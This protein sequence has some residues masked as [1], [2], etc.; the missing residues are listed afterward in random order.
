MTAEEGIRRFEW[1]IRDLPWKT[2]RD[3]VAELREHLAELPPGTSLEERLGT[4]E[5]YAADLRAA[6]GL[7]RQHGPIAFLRARRPR[8]LLATAIALTIVGLAIGALVWVNSYQPIAHG[9][10]GYEPD[11]HASPA[12][13]G[14]YVVFREG[15]A[16]A[17]GMS[18]RNSGRFTVRVLGVP[19]LLGLPIKYR[20]LTSTTFENGGIPRPFIPFH[21][22]DLKPGEQRGIIISGIYD[23]PCAGRWPGS[24]GWGSIPVR[25]SFLWHT[26]TAQVPLYQPLAFVFRKDAAAGCPAKP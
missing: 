2:K 14:E 17:Y 12:G 3:L 5:Q 4:P 9:Y 8:N 7:E 13:D 1:A 25:Y 22:F 6:A 15:K 21:P 24:I 23:T 26:A 10:T 20:V 16:F 18:I 19:K 11:V